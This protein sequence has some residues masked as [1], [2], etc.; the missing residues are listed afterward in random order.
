M[1]YRAAT[2]AVAARVTSSGSESEE[3][4]LP[5]PLPESARPRSRRL[6]RR[7]PGLPGRR[8]ATEY[9][10]PTAVVAAA[11]V[12]ALLPLVS[13][14]GPAA[15]QPADAET[16]AGEPTSSVAP[17]RGDASERGTLQ[18]QFAQA[19]ERHRVPERVLLGVAYLQSRWDAHHGAPSV[20]GGYGP[21]HLT[22]ADRAL[23][24]SD[25]RR[26]GKS[27]KSDRSG[28]SAGGR[29]AADL[30]KS[31]GSAG[32][33]AARGGGRMP[34]KLRTVERAARL[35]GESPERL[36]RST[37]ANLRG[38]A[39]LLAA[40]QRQLGRSLTSDP[41][42]WY[43]AV[44]AYPEGGEGG[45]SWAFADEVFDVLRDGKRRTTDAG[46]RVTL[47]ATPGLRPDAGQR[48]AARSS[49]AEEAECPARSR[50]EWSPAPYKKYTGENGEPD[51]GNHDRTRRPASQRI[52]TIVIHDLE[53]RYDRAM[54]LVKDPSRVS[55]NYTLRSSDGH[56]TQ[57]VRNRDVSWHAG[58]WDINAR[59]I[60]LEHEGFLAEPDAWFTEAMYRSSARLVRHLAEKYDVPLDREHILGHDNVPGANPKAI[61]EMHSDPGPYWDWR[62]YFELLGAPFS[63]EGGRDS[64]RS[65]DLVTILPTYSKHRPGFVGCE[66][67][68]ARCRPHGSGAVRLHTGPDASAPLVKDAGLRPDGSPS[69]T[70]VND[71]GARASTGQRYAVADRKGAWTAIW[72]L[73]QKAWFQNPEEQPTAVPA[74]GRM[75]T[76]KEGR[77]K[78]PVYGTAYPGKGAYPKDVPAQ[79]LTPLPY[80][81][82]AGQ[83][84][85]AG[86]K[87][88]G[89][90]LHAPDFDPDRKNFTVV[91]GG[92]SY[93]PVQLGHRLAYVKASDVRVVSSPGTSPREA[94]S[95]TRTGRS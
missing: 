75:V 87:R 41:S 63:P 42:D 20:S 55:W 30:V 69:T 1:E 46:E 79:Q 92:L 67:S 85:S 58:N 40:A 2:L 24:D 89:A 77:G 31:A 16:T 48:G 47:P 43:G 83:R 7:R 36:R 86:D 50:C 74:R 39:A 57:H 78:V 25:Q 70:G 32:E 23:A 37:A 6:A 19:A 59:S 26:G 71:T 35:T 62:H 81:M 11:V 60:G 91:K 68:G 88:T 10:R 64:D 93:Y 95:A 3:A 22:D 17:R 4:E 29:T 12:T 14:A 44:A 80:S 53:G 56:T 61:K 34:A 18:R 15:A 65:S 52:D 51:Y 21:M 94:A 27:R 33:P 45:P 90:Y 82:G 54:K 76:P 66:E 84:Y 8:R 13:D 72:Y 28:P 5:T 73:G 38:G 49:S 9:R